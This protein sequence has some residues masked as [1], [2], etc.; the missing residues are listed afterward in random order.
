MRS[1]DPMNTEQRDEM[2]KDHPLRK[3]TF[4][5]VT[6]TIEQAYASIREQIWLGRPS[7]YFYSTP[8]VGKSECAKAIKHFILS[9]SPDKY[10]VLVSCDVTEEETIVETLC[11]GIGLLPKSREKGSRL[12]AR[13]I[14]HISCELSSL[15]GNHF[16]LILDEMQALQISDYKHLQVIQNDLKIKGISTTTIGFAQSEINDLHAVL[17]QAKEDAI[18]ARFLSQRILFEGCSDILWLEALLSRFDESLFF[19]SGSD[20]SYTRFFLPQSFAN[21]FRLKDHAEVIYKTIRQALGAN[22][23]P[24]EHLF[25]MIEYIL[26][27]SRPDDRDSFV[28]SEEK[29]KSALLESN[30]CEFS[31]ILN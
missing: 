26:I 7:L 21:G 20:C 11:K 27:S 9:E 8:R 28:L 3:K 22:K 23:I 4:T 24:I 15:S 5:T 30:M 29:I 12:R 2:L 31:G 25:I 14:N 16:V 10:V 17:R 1:F 13:L 18:I 6:K 19:P